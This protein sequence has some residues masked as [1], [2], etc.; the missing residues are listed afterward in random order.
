[1]NREIVEKKV[2]T[3]EK[4]GALEMRGYSWAV[5]LNRARERSF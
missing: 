2:E 5:A 3:L 1:M 4:K